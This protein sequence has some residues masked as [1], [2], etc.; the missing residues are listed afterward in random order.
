[1]RKSPHVDVDRP[2]VAVVI[3][4]PDSLQ[5]HVAR[6][7]DSRVRRQRDEQSVFARFETDVAAVDAYFTRGLIDLEPSETAHARRSRRHCI[8]L[9]RKTARTRAITSRGEN[10]LTT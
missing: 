3:V 7:R 10:G 4:A 6:Q 2:L 9:R 1:M 8:P 5:Q